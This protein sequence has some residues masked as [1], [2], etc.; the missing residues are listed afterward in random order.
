MNVRTIYKG[1]TPMTGLV[2]KRTFEDEAA[3]ARTVAPDSRTDAAGKTL[4]IVL[5]PDPEC[6]TETGP[7]PD[8]D[9]HAAPVAGDRTSR[10]PVVA[11]RDATSR[12]ATD[13]TRDSFTELVAPLAPSEFLER[14]YLDKRPVLFRGARD[15]FVSLIDWSALGAMV[16][17]GFLKAPY[18]NLIHDGAAV[19]PHHYQ[20]PQFGL[21]WRHTAGGGVDAQRI[22]A[23]LR[24]GATLV[25]NEI[26]ALHPPIRALAEGL[27]AALGYSHVNLYASWREV[28][29][30]STHWDTHDVF[31]VQVAGC[32]RWDLFGESRS[33]P[34][35]RDVECD[36]GRDAP[37]TVL[38]SE[39]LGPGDVL[40]VPRGWWHCARTA[41]DAAGDR[42]G[43]LHLTCGIR[44]V[45]GQ[46]FMHW[47][48]ARLA[49]HETFRKEI[50]PRSQTV[51]YEA[52]FAALRELIVSALDGD[53]AREFGDF[54]DAA[55]SERA[56]VTLAD[57]IEPWRSPDWDRCEIRLPSAG[58]AVF[59]PQGS[60]GTAV[61]RA[62]GYAWS[63]DRGCA[64][65]LAPLVAAG[66]MALGDLKALASD[67][68]SPEFVDQFA[69]LL[70]EE[71]AA[72]AV[73]PEDRHPPH[74][75]RAS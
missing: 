23:L 71:G 64:D 36:L 4:R 29:G 62:N 67:R 15:R 48:M 20:T 61:L 32:K 54:M 50:P 14:Y 75:G 19:P 18:L 45:T 25:V 44:S 39:V 10:E 37:T 27:E 1:K 60:E 72:R 69:R 68:F 24:R 74:F 13:G 58:R 53:P 33:F 47:L 6:T 12:S 42:R 65:L 26:E 43:S 2:Q 34:M 30:F 35:N 21:G 31:V 41:S 46:L 70:I 59:E 51:P 56:T 16:S 49:E 38:W 55:W 73:M 8:A 28:Q 9:R 11:E 22:E 52:H 40:Y 3:I 57:Y 63:F 7:V 66:S 17:T 5:R